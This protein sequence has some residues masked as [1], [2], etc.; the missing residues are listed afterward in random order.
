VEIH[1]GASG[2]D[3]KLVMSE[4][5][6]G[7]ERHQLWYSDDQ[8]F[9]RSSLND[10]VPYAADSQQLVMKPPSSD[11]KG[12]WFV[13]GVKV[14]NKAGSC[15][16]VRGANKSD[17]AEVIAYKYKQQVNQAWDQSFI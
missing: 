12:Q 9:I 2:P 17:G 8:G 3:S 1:G 6:G 15:L 5:R 13:E 7:R 10:L 14:V 4:K 11:P 16:D